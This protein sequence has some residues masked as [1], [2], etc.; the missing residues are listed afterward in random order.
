MQA[1]RRGAIPV[2]RGF[3]ALCRSTH[4]AGSILLKYLS[5][6]FQAKGRRAK[7]GIEEGLRV[8]FILEGAKELERGNEI[9]IIPRS[10]SYS[11][12]EMQK[13]P[14]PQL[15]CLYFP[16]FLHPCDKQLPRTRT[17]PPLP[18]SAWVGPLSLHRVI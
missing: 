11:Q 10:F 8:T 5:N 4:H 16:S 3:R 15:L 7:A 14:H 18:P 1:E 13:S 17:P 12:Q 2:R 9:P 6:L